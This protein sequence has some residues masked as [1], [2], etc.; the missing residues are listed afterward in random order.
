MAA[1]TDITKR[2]WDENEARYEATLKVRDRFFCFNRCFSLQGDPFR[3][4]YQIEQRQRDKH[5]AW[6]KGLTPPEVAL[7]RLARMRL[8]NFTERKEPCVL[9]VAT[10][11]DD[12]LYIYAIGWEYDGEGEMFGIP[13]GL[14][15][16]ARPSRLYRYDQD[17]AKWSEIRFRYSGIKKVV[18][19]IKNNRHL[20]WRV[21]LNVLTGEVW[22]DSFTSLTYFKRYNDANIVEVLTIG[23]HPFGRYDNPT[24]AEIEDL[25]NLR[26]RKHEAEKTYR[27]NH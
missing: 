25:A 24:M 3:S 11:N 12:D 13:K 5:I 17:A 14:V 1:L 8:E 26:A 19:E 2:I 6:A 7:P 16:W 10:D 15:N 23:Q 18:G 21:N 9:W 27:V 4:E 22:G 20:A